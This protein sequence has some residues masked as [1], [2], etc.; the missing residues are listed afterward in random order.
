VALRD[1]VSPET[2]YKTFG[3]KTALIKDVYDVSL[4]GDDNPRALADR[5]RSRPSSPRPIPGGNWSSTP[6]SHGTS[7][8][9]S[10]RCSPGSARPPRAVATTYT[11]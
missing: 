2:I 9:G 7:A 11:I 1:R 3:S 8:S 6:P 5:P 10:L 4:A